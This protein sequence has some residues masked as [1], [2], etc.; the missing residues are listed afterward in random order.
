MKVDADIVAALKDALGDLGES[1]DGCLPAGAVAA[2]AGVSRPG[3]RLRI[4]LEASRNIGAPLVT[5]SR[6]AGDELFAAL[7]PRQSDVARLVVAGQSNRQIA[8]E[9]GISIATV[10]DHVHAILQRLEM[11]SRQAVMAAARGS[12]AG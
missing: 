2:L 9:L 10:K 6:E 4:D 12:G 5:I 3:L 8:E 1:S 7:T 11:P